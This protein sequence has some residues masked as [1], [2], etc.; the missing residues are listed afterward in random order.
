[1]VC[2]CVIDPPYRFSCLSTRIVQSLF[3]WFFIGVI[4]FRY[5]PNSVITRPVESVWL[6]LV[7]R[8]FFG[9][10]Y[11][12]RLAMGWLCLLAIIFGSAFG[13]KVPEVCKDFQIACNLH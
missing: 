5:I 10:N 3:A 13:F 7:Q 8:P 4:A 6:P 11:R 1:M 9:L 12:I 2:A